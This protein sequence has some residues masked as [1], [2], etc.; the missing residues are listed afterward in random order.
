M[1]ISDLASNLPSKICHPRLKGPLAYPRVVLTKRLEGR[2]L[3]VCR[4][5][6]V[7]PTGGS[8]AESQQENTLFS[9]LRYSH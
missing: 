7:E 2:I 8:M 6:Y 1:K 3:Q 4:T 5:S 9:G